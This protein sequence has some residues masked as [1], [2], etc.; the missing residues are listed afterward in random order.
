MPITL[1]APIRQRFVVAQRASPGERVLLPKAAGGG[2]LRLSG[3]NRGVSSRLLQAT[4][5]G[6]DSGPIG[7]FD[8][9]ALATALALPAGETP[10]LPIVPGHC[11][12]PA[13]E[14]LRKPPE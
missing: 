3:L 4:H 8:A 10:A 9:D 13:P 11:S 7:G 1:L 2:R 12:D 14:R 5:M 6:L